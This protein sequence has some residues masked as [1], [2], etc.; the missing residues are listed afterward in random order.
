MFAPKGVDFKSG[1]L[2]EIFCKKAIGNIL[3][4]NIDVNI[5]ILITEFPE[6]GIK[7]IEKLQS[8]C[9]SMNFSDKSRYG[10]IS[11]K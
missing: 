1:R 11:S 6:D 5:I 10:R 8:H 3:N 9:A 4:A 7:C 2:I